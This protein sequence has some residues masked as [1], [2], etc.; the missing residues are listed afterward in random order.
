[1]KSVSLDFRSLLTVAMIAASV[2]CCCS[3][4][5]LGRGLAFAF[6]G[7]EREPGVVGA[8]TSALSSGAEHGC[9][10]SEKPLEAPAPGDGSAPCDCGQSREAK[11]LPEEMPSVGGPAVP[12]GL[13]VAAEAPIWTIPAHEPVRA[14]RAAAVPLP[15]STL[16]RQHCALII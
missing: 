4:R 16:L 5:Y 1:M 11:Q 8:L 2:L 7:W 10:G 15:P 9:C 6:S 13:A 12:L 14:T 3:G